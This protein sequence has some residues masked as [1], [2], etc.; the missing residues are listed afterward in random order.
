M[1]AIRWERWA[2][3]FA[4]VA[5]AWFSA[6]AVGLQFVRAGQYDWV[7]A[8]LS[9]YLTGLHGHWLVNA[10]YLMGV[11]LIALGLGLRRQIVPEARYSL[12]PLFF[13][14]GGI[15]LA[16]TARFHDGSEGNEQ[17]VMEHVV[18]G[19]AAGLSFV[20]L[21]FAMMLQS[22]GLRRDPR[23]QDSAWK[24][25]ALAVFAFALMWCHGIFKELPRGA[26]QK[27]VI[28]AYV[29]WLAWTAGKLFRFGAEPPQAASEAVRTQ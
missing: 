22:F 12:S 20:L 3:L 6:N 29:V 17:A 21:G 27:A 8:P 19:L 10:Y 7:N 26:S 24:L 4:L 13:A 5:L 11:G 23:W 25:L 16:L 14:L 28:A 18:H 1:D 2:G 15:A 9:H